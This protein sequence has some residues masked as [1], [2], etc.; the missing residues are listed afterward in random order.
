MKAL[1]VM[2]RVQNKWKG[3]SNMGRQSLLGTWRQLY[4]LVVVR[5]H[6]LLLLMGFLLGRAVMLEQ[7]SPF[8]L[9]FLAV[10]YYI[11]R[12]RWLPVAIALL[13]GSSTVPN[14]E[15]GWMLA[16]FLL[17]LV[18][19]KGLERWKK[20]DINYAPLVV[21]TTLLG[22]QAIRL[23]AGG[24]SAYGGVLALVEIVLSVLLTFIFVQSLPIFTSKRR[25]YALRA[26]EMVCLVILLASVMTGMVGWAIGDMSVAHIFSRYF[27]LMFAFVGGGMLGTTVG[28]VMGMILSLSNQQAMLEISLLAFAGLLAG[29]FREG[30]KWG[31]SIGLLVGTA[32]LALYAGPEMALWVSVQESLLAV[33]LFLITPASWTR[34]LARFIPGTAENLHSQQEYARRVRDLTAKKVEQFSSLFAD[35]SDSFSTDFKRPQ[36]DEEYLQHFVADLSDSACARCR[37]Y[38]EC[39]GTKFYQTYNGITDLVA[40]VELAENKGKIKVPQSWK[41]HCIKSDHMMSLTRKKYETYQQELR[42][43][44]RLRETQQ[45][46]S[47]Q[48]KGMSNV[49]TDWAFDIR[50]ETQVL[51]AQEEQIQ[52]A[53]EDLGMSIHRVDVISLDEGNVEVEVTLP[54][55]DHLDSCR[56]IIA[57]LL[58]DIVGEHITVHQKEGPLDTRDGLATVTLGSAQNYEVHAGVAKAAKG[59]N[60]HSGD[61]YSYMNLGTGK[62]AVAISDGMGNGTRAQEES[63]EALKLLERLL[64]SGMEE[65]TAVKTVNTILGMRSDEEI[66]ATVDLAL[67]D[68]DTARTTFLKIGSTPSFIKRGNEVIPVTASNLP[69]GILKEIEVDTVSKRLLPGDMLIMVTDG[70]YDAPSA[71]V[72]KEAWMKRAIREIRIRDPQGFADLL[73][74]KAVRGRQ[75]AI[76]DDMTVVVAKVDHAIPDWATISVPG[77]PRI[78]RNGALSG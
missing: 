65:Q 45:I 29:L 56:K 19:Q 62:Y 69:I 51:S 4:N 63:R 78:K 68:L 58:T 2:Q 16:T 74:E 60:W 15:T 24:W 72:N 22:S 50:R 37:K 71:D 12:D 46:V 6:L 47:E 13:F 43:K 53:L 77:L 67:I 59:G 21:L 40:L 75:G 38:D 11:K 73:L 39:W 66:Y 3:N 35:L 30:K 25:N 28:L 8:A 14:G 10:V 17:F 42:W 1:T 61:S 54:H 49:M 20:N 5:W 33:I 76:T 27:I 70:I 9:P 52:N 7:V 18:L 31:V 23:G 41:N 44:E 36:Q 26:E 64:Q 48:L 34:A 32:I 57:P 55:N